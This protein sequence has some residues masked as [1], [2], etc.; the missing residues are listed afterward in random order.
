[1]SKSASLELGCE[2]CRTVLCATPHLGQRVFLRVVLQDDSLTGYLKKTGKDEASGKGARWMRAALLA[3][4]QK[5]G[6]LVFGCE[7]VHLNWC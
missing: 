6:L 5:L 3:H 4:T 2:F 7:Q 1:M